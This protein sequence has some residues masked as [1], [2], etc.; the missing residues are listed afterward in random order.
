MVFISDYELIKRA[1]NAKNN[2][3]MGRPDT[4]FKQILTQGHGFNIFFS[5]YGPVLAS[6]RRV[7]LSAVRYAMKQY[8]IIIMVSINC[9]ELLESK[10]LMKTSHNWCQMSWMKLLM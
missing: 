9:I 5:D 1:F 3:F 7:G 6:L 2:E 4:V 8:F 10:Q